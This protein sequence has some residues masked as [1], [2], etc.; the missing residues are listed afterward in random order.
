MRMYQRR[1]PN[2]RLP[3]SSLHRRLRETGTFTTNAHDH[4]RPRRVRTPEVEE[5]ILRVFT[6]RPHA[7]TRGVGYALGIHHVLVWEVLRDQQLHPFHLQRVH[8]L[9]P[10]DYPLRVAFAQWYLQQT[11][12]QPEF[13]SRVL[14]TDEA[15]FA[16]DSVFNMHNAH[17]WAAANPHASHE[18]GHQVRFSVNVWAAS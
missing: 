13:P 9:L 17:V 11:A 5:E 14:F 18:H 4:G 16:R 8:A 15:C 6:N 2:R 7:S 10:E 12:L 1:F 3:F